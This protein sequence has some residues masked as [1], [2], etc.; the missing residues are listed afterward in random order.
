MSHYSTLLTESKESVLTI[1]LN[2][3][4]VHNAFD[5][6]L[7]AELTDAVSA[8]GLDA[9]LRAVVLRGAGPSFCAG[10]DLN[11]MRRMADYSQEENLADARELQR[12]FETIARCPKVTVAVVHG[13]A[14]G[15]GAGL[16]AVCDVAIATPEA[17]FAL[18]EVR[19][20]LIPAVIAP[21]VVEKTGRGTAR[22]LFV[23]GE[24][25]SGEEAHRIGLVHQL[26]SAAELERALE[27]KLA[28][29]RQ[30]GPQAIAAAKQLL[31]ELDGK[32]AE[33]AA[34]LT[35]QCIAAL[36]IS[37][38]GQ[39]GIRAFLEKRKPSFAE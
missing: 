23:S 24:R 30:A 5:E 28:L 10:A 9:Q 35:T 21:Y 27:E 16:A 6:T 31:R 7:I 17:K 3:P 32:S 38:E 12:M 29:V 4:G 36:R 13:A 1:T 2:R 19:L 37:P 15:G 11:W 25:F 14:I 18:S 26:V 22:A 20:G 8:A 39:E 33:A 34:E